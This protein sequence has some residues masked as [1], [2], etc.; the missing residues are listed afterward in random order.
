MLA[1]G[2]MRTTFVDFLSIVNALTN[3]HTARFGHSSHL[4]VHNWT[5]VQ[6][7]FVMQISDLRAISASYSI[8]V[9]WTLCARHCT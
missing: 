4:S 7:Y 5:N 6:M 3:T 2:R 8:R 1:L 9:I